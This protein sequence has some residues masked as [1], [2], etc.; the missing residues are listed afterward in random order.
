MSLLGPLLPLALLAA[1]DL[2][3]ADPAGL[4]APRPAP[5]HDGPDPLAAWDLTAA[6][7]ELSLIH[8]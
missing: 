2:A 4:V 8:I 5:L 6:A 7:V 3:A 1:V